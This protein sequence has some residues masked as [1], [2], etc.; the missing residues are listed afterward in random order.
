MPKRQPPKTLSAEAGRLWCEIAAAYA[1]KDERGAHLLTLAFEQF[2]RMREAQRSIAA[3][4]AIT[5]DRYG[6]PRQNPAVMIENRAQRTHIATLRE[7]LKG[8][9]RADAGA[10][11]SRSASVVALHE[12][13]GDRNRK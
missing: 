3:H 13:I 11:R 4:G 12:F 8:K 2:D 10:D 6:N 1:V 5:S 7:A 9:K